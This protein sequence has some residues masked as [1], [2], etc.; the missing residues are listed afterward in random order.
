MLEAVRIGHIYMWI[1]RGARDSRSPPGLSSLDG[2]SRALV[3]RFLS[4]YQLQDPGRVQQ[5]QTETDLVHEKLRETSQTRYLSKHV[6]DFDALQGREFKES[7]RWSSF[8][9]LPAEAATPLFVYMKNFPKRRKS[10]IFLNMHVHV[11]YNIM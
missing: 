5:S 1:V 10:A 3:L 7:Q 11:S 2:F 8:K 9:T 6:R 4:F